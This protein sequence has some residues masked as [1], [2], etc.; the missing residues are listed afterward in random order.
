MAL[1][2]AD[3]DGRFACV[4]DQRPTAHDATVSSQEPLGAHDVPRMVD[5]HGERV[6]VVE[7][8]RGVSA[9]VGVE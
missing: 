4:S 3:A 8:V 9:P 1:S 5:V 2:T 7:A 6:G